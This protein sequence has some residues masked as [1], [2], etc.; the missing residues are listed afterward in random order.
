[1][2]HVETPLIFATASFLLVFAGP[3]A[4]AMTSEQSPCLIQ[5]FFSFQTQSNSPTYSPDVNL[6]WNGQYSAFDP[7]G[8]VRSFNL[9][10]DET[11]PM[12]FQDTNSGGGI[13]LMGDYSF[14]PQQ[15]NSLSLECYRD[16]I[17]DGNKTVPSEPASVSGNEVHLN[18]AI[19]EPL[20]LLLLATGAALFLRKRGSQIRS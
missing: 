12:D 8:Q 5:G 20:S 15:F 14:N 4:S 17:F 1:V 13:S 19:P 16:P 6:N 2:K 10:A 7:I 11:W 9:L 3:A 18:T